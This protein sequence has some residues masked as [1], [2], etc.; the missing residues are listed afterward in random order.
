MEAPLTGGTTYYVYVTGFS[1]NSGNFVLTT[2]CVDVLCSPTITDLV[3]V[4]SEGTPLECVDT[5][6]EYYLQVT[7]AGGTQAT[8]DVT[9]GGS[10][11]T[12]IAAEGTGIVGPIPGGD[13]TVNAVGSTDPT[14]SASAPYT[15]TACP[16]PNDEACTA[17]A[18]SCGDSYSNLSFEGATQSFDDACSGSGTADVW[19]TFTADGAQTYNIAETQ[20]DV[21]VDLWIGDDC[22]AIS[23]VEAC[24][25]FPE[26]FEVTAA[27]T[28]YFR[29]RPWSTFTTTYGV[30]LTCTPFDCPGVGNIGDACDDGDAGTVNDEILADCS[31]AGEPV[32]VND[33]ACTAT[34]LFCGDTLS[35]Q[36]FAGSS[37]SV[38]DACSGSGTGDVWFTFTADGTQSYFIEETETDVVVDL[39]IG[40]DC[41]AITS[42]SDC[43]DFGEN[44]TVNEAGTYYFRIRPWST[45]TT[46]YGVALTCTPFECPLVGGNIGD[47]CDDNDP[48]TANDEIQA[49]CSCAGVP[50]ATNDEPC[51]ATAC[52]WCSITANNTRCNSDFT[53]YYL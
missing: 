17:I 40:D 52:L 28:Y 23:Q 41:G 2:S 12:V 29:I 22:G 43:V 13:V 7:L 49:D 19:Y 24:S 5:F 48:L 21:V 4:D 37:Q 44:F 3:A 53:S 46:T 20:T 30:S 36:S 34:E 18:L 26:N 27:G 50:V 10:P 8:Y 9:A 15:I 39:W 51:G 42:I 35:G 31:C 6:G 38:D 14:C 1:S 11:A 45:F 47:P 16:P 32:A 33:E 25:D